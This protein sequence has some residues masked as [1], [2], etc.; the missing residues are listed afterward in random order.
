MIIQGKSEGYFEIFKDLGNF[1]SQDLKKFD[2]QGY[3]LAFVPLCYRKLLKRGFNQAEVLARTI[4]KNLNLP[5]YD[6]LLK[7]KETKDQAN[8]SYEERLTN[9]KNA[10][11]LKNKPPEKIILVDDIKTTGSTL[12]ECAQVLKKAGAKK[13]IAL[14]VLK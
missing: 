6:G 3:Y 1:I 7:I 2:F 12:K 11:A 4:S 9:L 14:T 5:L 13:I 8:L 10:F